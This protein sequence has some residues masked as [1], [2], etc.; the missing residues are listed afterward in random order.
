MGWEG[1]SKQV[2]LHQQIQRA[3]SLDDGFVNA[4]SFARAHSD[5][6]NCNI[7]VWS[8]ERFIATLCKEMG[9]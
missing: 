5:Q 3:L 9:N 6:T 8:R 1:C 7:G 2:A 4:S